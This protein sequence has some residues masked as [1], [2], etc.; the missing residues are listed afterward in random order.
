MV[1][2]QLQDRLQGRLSVELRIVLLHAG[3]PHPLQVL[4]GP[5]DSE[6]AGDRLHEA[7][8]ALEDQ[9]R[10]G[11]PARRQEGGVGAGGGGV[12]V[13]QALPVGEGPGAGDPQRVEGGPADGQGV[14]GAPRIQPQGPGD[15]RRHGIGALGGVVEPP[16][17]HGGHI[18]KPTLHL[19]GHRQRRQQGAPVP[20]RIFGGGQHRPQVVAGVAGLAGGDVAVVEVEVADQSAV[21]E[22]RAVGRAR[23]PAHQSAARC[24]S[25]LLH[26]GADQPNGLA[27]QRADG[28]TQRV[29]H[30]DL[31]LL[32]RL[33]GKVLVGGG[34]DKRCQLLGVG[35]RFTPP[36]ACAP[37]ASTAR[38]WWPRSPKRRT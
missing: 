4:P 9:G 12:G 37:P 30:A 28:T 31:Q 16:G 27:V 1:G 5:V 7:L 8:V 19:V 20:A 36:A 35:H 38:R 23:A 13:G 21:V 10:A 34:D 17:P 6:A 33:G 18:G 26:V 2:P 3:P 15:A 29:Q 22:G 14:G 24:A 32:H 11:D 25:E